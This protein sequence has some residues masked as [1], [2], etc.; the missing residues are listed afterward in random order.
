MLGLMLRVRAVL[1]SPVSFK[2]VLFGFSM[3][4]CTSRR[5][6]PE[7]VETLQLWDNSMQQ[8]ELKYLRTDQAVGF[9]LW[10]K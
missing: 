2:F 3:I 6:H 4:L 9:S 1:L 8:Q 5:S 10:A 7:G